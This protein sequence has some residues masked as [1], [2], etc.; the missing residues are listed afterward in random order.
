MAP[1]RFGASFDTDGGSLHR[2]EAPLQGNHVGTEDAKLGSRT[3][4]QQL[5]VGYQCREVRHG[6]DTQEDERRIPAGRDAL[7]QDVE[8]RAFFVDADLQPGVHVEGN[9]TYQD[10]EADGDEQ[11][12]LEFLGNGQVDEEQTYH[13][14]DEMSRRGVGKPRIGPEVGQVVA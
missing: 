3:D 14:H 5:G 2:V 11:H 10:T 8:H 9:V 13:E 12:R 6:T 7:I 4:E 1:I